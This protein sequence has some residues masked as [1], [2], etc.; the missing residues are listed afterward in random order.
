M[1]NINKDTNFSL[2]G[3]DI[4]SRLKRLL[5]LHI[6]N[7]EDRVIR[8][9]KQWNLTI[10]DHLRNETA[11]RLTIGSETQTVP[12]K[13]EDGVPTSFGKI[14]DQFSEYLELLL[15]LPTLEKSVEGLRAILENHSTISRKIFNDNPFA[16]YDDVKRTYE[17]TRL[18]VANLKKIEFLKKLGSIQHDIFGAYFHYDSFIEIYW[19]PIALTSAM[20]GVSVE[21]LAFVTLAHEIAHAY[22]HLG[23]DIDG[24]QWNTDSFAETNDHIVEGLAQFYTSVICEKL[25]VRFPE[26][27]ITY[28]K[29][30]E[31]DTGAYKAHTEW[32]TNEKS[33]G[34]IIR[35]SMIKCRT[36]M[37]TDYDAFKELLENEIAALKTNENL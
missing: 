11:L 14:A 31:I 23:K 18:T 17:L 2:F 10:R 22:T 25:S 8:A 15:L 30:L 36:Q 3:E 34:E 37:I 21:S 32:A 35:V 33:R 1:E 28:R 27:L 13:I 29:L 16:D 20:L 4:T 24:Q 12:I 7:A 26:A 5:D 19:I 9:Y 6:P